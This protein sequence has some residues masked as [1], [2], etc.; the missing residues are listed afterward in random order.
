MRIQRQLSHFDKFKQ[1]GRT[2]KLISKHKT[3]LLLRFSYLCTLKYRWQ[4][5]LEYKC[6]SKRKNVFGN[7]LFGLSIELNYHI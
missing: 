6:T 1:N 7:L 3:T 4:I 5:H 2:T